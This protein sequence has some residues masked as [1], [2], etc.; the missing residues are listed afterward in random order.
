MVKQEIPAVKIAD[1]IEIA[2]KPW[3]EQEGVV[4]SS[5]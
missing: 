1:L 3:G 2:A 4:F 5:D